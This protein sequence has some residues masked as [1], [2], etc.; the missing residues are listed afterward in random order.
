VTRDIDLLRKMKCM[1]ALSIT[2]KS[3]KLSRKLEPHA[4]V[5][6]ERLEAIKVLVRKG[7]PVAVRI[8]PIIP[9][10]NDEPEHLIESLAHQG[11]SHVTSSTYKI[12][13]D[14]WRRFNRAFPRIAKKLS[15]LY[16]EKG[17]RI[18][19]YLYLPRDLR[20]RI[21]QR[22]KDLT[23]ENGMKF[24]CCREGFSHLNSAVCDGS[25]LVL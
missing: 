25:W 7:I 8:D 3:D 15:P 13:P 23:E 19:G 12:R 21:M 11:V 14:N 1:V 20:H 5:S 6:S 24:G 16:F 17:E 22:V 18:S 10:I 9:F 2:T 4:P